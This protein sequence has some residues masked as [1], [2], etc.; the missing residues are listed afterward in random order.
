MK[1]QLLVLG[2]L[3]WSLTSLFGQ[4]IT[5]HLVS[6]THLNEER[7]V[8]IFLPAEV[9][10]SQAQ[11]II[12]VFDQNGL[13]DLVVQTVQYL[14][15]PSR[16]FMPP[17]V[18]VGIAGKYDQIENELG[19]DFR[20]WKLSER[21]L[22]FSR[23]LKEELPLYLQTIAP[24]TVDFQIMIGQGKSGLYVQYFNEYY[25][26]FLEAMVMIAPENSN[27]ASE[28]I[29]PFAS[30]SHPKFWYMASAD[31][32]LNSRKQFVRKTND[33]IEKHPAPNLRFNYDSIP[34]VGLDELALIALPNAFK[35]IYQ[36][37]QGGAKL[38]AFYARNAIDQENYF[39]LP[40][41]HNL[42]F[43]QLPLRATAPTATVLLSKALEFD[44]ASGAQSII[45]HFNEQNS[46][47]ADLNALLAEFLHYDLGR[48][49]QAESL[50]LKAIEQ[51]HTN[52]SY[53]SI[54]AYLKLM[55][56]YKSQK[57]GDA[58][59]NLGQKART[60]LEV[61][62]FDYQLAE[63][64]HDFGI[65]IPEAIELLQQL[66]D[67]QT[68]QKPIDTLA[69]KFLLAK[70]YQKNGQRDLARQL[71]TEI[72]QEKENHTG[73]KQLLENL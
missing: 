57:K 70:L 46:K 55:D 2:V 64:A 21:G 48:Q 44:D 6:S 58:A 41:Q 51:F 19:F 29:E 56:L 63:I 25:P 53:Q 27:A 67:L 39:E 22:L 45:D 61:N 31:Y 16:D 43:Y 47:S 1:K 73:A 5:N 32:D 7:P 62:T 15:H 4:S 23:F 42:R 34:N 52:R 33:F 8:R 60:I 12:F 54:P 59:W 11:H 36:E 69:T 40:N 38:E 35:F 26:S 3:L 72:I 71:A 49:K 65:H 20:N 28:L 14:A 66:G 9:N 24:N 30:L 13:F 18:V 37:Y 10:S 50:Y 17:A 68:T